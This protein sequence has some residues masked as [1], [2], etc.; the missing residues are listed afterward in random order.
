MS[1]PFINSATRLYQTL[2]DDLYH[3]HFVILSEKI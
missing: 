1:E 2:N 3:P